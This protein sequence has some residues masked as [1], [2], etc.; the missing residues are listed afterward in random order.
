MWVSTFV[1]R[2]GG[3]D[4]RAKLSR[5]SQAWG[6]APRCGASLHCLPA[7][8]LQVLHGGQTDLQQPAHPGETHPGA[9]RDQGD[10]PDQEPGGRYR[11]DRDRHRA[12]TGCLWSLGG[13]AKGWGL[14]EVLG[15]VE[16]IALSPGPASTCPAVPGTGSS[17]PLGGPAPA[18]WVR[19]P[20]GRSLLGSRLSL[21]AR[22]GRNLAQPLAACGEKAKCPLWLRAAPG[23]EGRRRLARGAQASQRLL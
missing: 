1:G 2:I 8:A 9:T 15:R 16:G 11:P 19:A 23:C 5:G 3:Q 14:A 12:G 4:A 22:Q 21:P 13:L 6:W 10:R 7:P 20:S 18:G 17:L